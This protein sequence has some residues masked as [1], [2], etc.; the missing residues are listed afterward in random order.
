MKGTFGTG[1]V[2]LG[3]LALA[4]AGSS[5]A[6][7]TNLNITLTCDDAFEA[8]ISTNDSVQGTSFLTDD[9]WWPTTESGSTALTPGMTNYLHI[10]GWDLYGAVSALIASLSLSDALFEFENGLQTL[11]TDTTYWGLSTTGWGVN[12]LTPTDLGANGTGP[13]G[14]I[15]GV[16]GA[17]RFI[18]NGTGGVTGIDH[19][20][21]VKINPVPEPA[22]LSALALGAAALLRRRRRK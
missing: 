3:A 5:A 8:F 11:D 20:F 13:W 6:Y 22:T 16:N 9:N 15:G 2:R 21:S 12:D 4:I 17:A 1:S 10:K 18:W 7:A 14:T 19:Y